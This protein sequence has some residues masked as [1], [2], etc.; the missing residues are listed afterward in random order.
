MHRFASSI[1]ALALGV[2]VTHGRADVA[3]ACSGVGATVKIDPFEC[4]ACGGGGLITPIWSVSG[5][6]FLTNDQATP[7]L[8]S[9]V[10]EIQ[11]PIG[12]K[13]V[14]A[15]RLVLDAAGH[16]FVD[17]CK[18]GF[19]DGPTEGR[20]VL[21]DGQGNEVSFQDVQNLPEG[22]AALNF[23]ATFAGPVPGLELG[24]RARVKIYTTAIG[25]HGSLLCSVDADGNGIVDQDVKTLVFQ[26]SLT[27]PATATL[28]N[29]P[30]P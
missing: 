4:G 29:P 21:T 7:V 6:V 28:I 19:A 2:L 3:S 26:K 15:A 25:V 23:I 13:Y 22:T 16:T 27:V 5:T 10:V 14:P 1:L 17:T 11:T 8:A 12:F 18:G 9:I 24:G 30:Q 20:I